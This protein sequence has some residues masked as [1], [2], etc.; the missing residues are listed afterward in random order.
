MTGIAGRTA[1]CGEGESRYQHREARGR[2]FAVAVGTCDPYA[3]TLEYWPW[4]QVHRAL[5]TPEGT[6]PL[7]PTGR[8]TLGGEIV[9]LSGAANGG[10]A[11]DQRRFRL[12]DTAARALVR[13]TRRDPADDGSLAHAVTSLRADRKMA[14]VTT[15]HKRVSA[16]ATVLP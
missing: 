7:P 10:A 1:L 2:G 15:R 6:E 4:R 12:F 9:D 5:T 11:P 13:R 3:G 16:I 14:I 8:F